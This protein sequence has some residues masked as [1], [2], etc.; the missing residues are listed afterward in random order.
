MIGSTF[1]VEKLE[2]EK[3]IQLFKMN[4]WDKFGRPDIEDFGGVFLSELTS[5]QQYSLILKFWE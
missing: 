2:L 4:I 5:Q 1:G 3:L